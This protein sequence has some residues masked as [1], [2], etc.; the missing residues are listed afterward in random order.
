MSPIS[1]EDASLGALAALIVCGI[2]V[3]VY[4]RTIVVPKMLKLMHHVDE[5]LDPDAGLEA[6]GES[7]AARVS[8]R[9]DDLERT[10]HE[11]DLRFGFV[12]YNS[13]ADVGSDL[14]FSVA[15]VTDEGN[16]VVL[17]SI[18]S[19]EETRTYGKGVEAWS[20]TQGASDEEK[21]AIERAR[22]GGLAASVR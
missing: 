1:I 10:G 9:L 15:L 22:S 14:S 21:R 8:R 13:F 20:P 12:R 2:V 3:A 4:H 17:T 6:L 11:R 18:Y 7:F 19:R 5:T 16:G